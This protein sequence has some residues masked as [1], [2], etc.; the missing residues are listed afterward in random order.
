MVSTPSQI[1]TKSG[2]GKN[3]QAETPAARL[4]TISW[5]R[6][7]RENASTEPNRTAKGSSFWAITGSFRRL[8]LS[9]TSVGIPLAVVRLKRSARSSERAKAAKAPNTT[10][11]EEVNRRARY[12][13]SVSDHVTSLVPPQMQ[14]TVGE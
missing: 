12:A 10:S 13:I 14:R 6:D 9:T 11:T 5:L 7:N 3:C 8:M 1:A 2:G 4:A